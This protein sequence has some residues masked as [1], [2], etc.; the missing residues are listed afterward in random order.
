M[1][2]RPLA[3]AVLEVERKFFALAVAELTQHGG[4]PAF[5]ALQAL[6]ARTIHD[7]YFDRNGR[8]AA[9]GTW[10]RRRNGAWG[11]KIRRG[12]DYTNSRFEEVHG[13]AVW[14]QVGAVLGEVSGEAPEEGEGVSNGG[15]NTFGLLTTADFV[16]HRQTWVADDEFRIVLDTMDF[17]HAVGEVE[18]QQTVL[19]PADDA[20]AAER[21]KQAVMQEMDG[22]IVAFMRRYAWAFAAGTP[23]GKLTAYFAMQGAGR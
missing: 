23:A 21:L 3:R 4:T 12:G 17:G 16:T 18:L 10:V 13:E 5:R 11:A 20:A 15:P 9:A 22:Q 6:P 1:A 2:S 14:A 8:L 7:T 19:V